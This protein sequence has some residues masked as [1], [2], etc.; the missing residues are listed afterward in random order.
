METNLFGR[1]NSIETIA[2]LCT[3]NN[4][5]RFLITI[6]NPYSETKTIDL[7][8]TPK[9]SADIEIDTSTSSPYIRINYK[10]IG[11]IDSMS[12]DSKYL[13]SEVLDVISSACN[14]YLKNIFIDSLYKTSKEFK[15]DICGLGIYSFKNFA[16]TKEFDDYNWLENYK[17]AFFD[18]NV[19]TSI[20]SGMLITE[21]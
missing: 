6:P 19:D 14:D 16:T 10:F 20:K 18:V 3:K 2:F 21:T 13:T 1:L 8:L 4:V 7:Y 17:N 15:S 9:N 12:E 5:D 11:R